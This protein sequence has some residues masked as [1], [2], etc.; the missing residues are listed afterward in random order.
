MNDDCEKCKHKERSIDDYP[1]S[2][3]S[4]V[5]EQHDYFDE[6]LKSKD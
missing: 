6:K 3:C 5:Q 4:R 1:C 2:N